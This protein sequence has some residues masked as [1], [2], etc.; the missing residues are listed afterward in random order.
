MSVYAN[1]VELTEPKTQ[2][3]NIAIPDGT[4][5]IKVYLVGGGGGVSH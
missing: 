4:N 1:Y 5:Q 2:E 3:Y